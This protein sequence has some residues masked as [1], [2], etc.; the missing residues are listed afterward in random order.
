MRR[1]SV[2]VP[3][4]HHSTLGD[5]MQ[6][7]PRNTAPHALH[8]QPFWQR[9]RA[10]S[11]YPF[12]GSALFSLI[13]LTLCTLTG[14]LPGIGWI[15]VLITWVAI[16]RY[17]FEILRETA[18]GR[19]D[20]PEHTLG[21][22]DSTVLKLL[23]LMVM[24]GISVVVVAVFLGPV[25]AVLALA[26]LVFLQPGCVIS[27]A[28]DGSLRTALNPATSLGMAIRIGWP[29]LAAFGLLF[30]IEASALT[31]SHWVNSLLPPV[32]GD[33]AV[34]FFSIWGLFAAFH[35]MGYLVYQYHDALGFEPDGPNE[36]LSRQDPDQ[37][38]LD[39]AEHL[40]REGQ[41]EAAL[42]SLR[43]T[44]R[45]RAVGLPVHELYQRLLRRAV[46]PDE[47][48][49]H[50]RQYL[51]RLLMEKQERKALALL[52]EALE[53]DPDFT[54]QPQENAVLLVDR[55]RL[56]GQLQLC[57]DALQAMVR[58]W[59]KAEQAP[60]WALEAALLLAER[61]NR[62]ADARRLLE[63]ALQR[64]E[65]D[66]QRRKLQAAINALNATTD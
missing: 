28:I 49:E 53:S 54:A 33:L 59:P 10:I 32:V 18:H 3:G 20:A 21:S 14:L 41:P 50:T 24:L 48:R 47:L 40:V 19:L 5:V 43:G 29:Y 44:I 62:D 7:C 6:E 45:S 26:L 66:E 37:T 15:L 38:L 23:L 35:L 57:A 42:E 1:P 25:A 9:L 4:N 65:D 63:D 30:V 52:R 55:A 60:H 64:C 56:S 46:R 31:A 2:D 39:Q 12:R 11:L 61:Y 17:S 16:Y 58:A 8:P 51:N 27:L 22:S 34:T 36:P 13:T